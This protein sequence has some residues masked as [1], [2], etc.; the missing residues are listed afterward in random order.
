MSLVERCRLLSALEY[1]TARPL[2]SINPYYQKPFSRD[3]QG[4][5]VGLEF[6]GDTFA[7]V[8]SPRFFR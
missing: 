6:E 1:L 3:F 8:N 7:P 4:G 2:L 5:W